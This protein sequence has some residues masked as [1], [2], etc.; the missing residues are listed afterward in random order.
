ML[1]FAPTAQER[2]Y[3]EQAAAFADHDAAIVDRHLLI[4]H[5]PTNSTGSFAGEAVSVAGNADLR[6]QFGVGTG[7]FAVLL[8]GKDGGV[9]LRSDVPLTA[10]RIFATIDSMPMRQREMR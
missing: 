10:D 7:D 4:G 1:I 5:F 2:A 9:K 3:V 8:I 6:E